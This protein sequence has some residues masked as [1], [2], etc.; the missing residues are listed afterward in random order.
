MQPQN[1]RRFRL[2]LSFAAPLGTPLGDFVFCL[3]EFKRVIFR[4]KSK[5]LKAH[6]S[7][8]FIFSPCCRST[9]A[10]CKYLRAHVSFKFVSPSNES[11]SEDVTCSANASSTFKHIFYMALN[12]I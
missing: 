4:K 2:R 10:R 6:P 1:L 11:R 5:G 8:S 9:Y 12:P 3:I 7:S